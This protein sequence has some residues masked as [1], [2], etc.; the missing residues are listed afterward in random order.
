MTKSPETACTV[1]SV[2][3][4]REECLNAAPEAM[5]FGEAPEFRQKTF[6]A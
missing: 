4:A 2:F 5:R 6:G 3:I 1:R